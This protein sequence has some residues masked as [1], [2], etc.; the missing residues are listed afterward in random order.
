MDYGFPPGGLERLFARCDRIASRGMVHEPPPREPE[1]KEEPKPAEPEPAEPAE[2]QPTEQP[3]EPQSEPRAAEMADAQLKTLEGY[4]QESWGDIDDAR[5]EQAQKRMDERLSNPNGASLEQDE[6]GLDQAYKD[7]TAPGVFYDPD[8]RTEYITG[9]STPRDW[10][11]DFTKIPFW[12]DT[13]NSERYQQA[14][15][16]YSKLQSAGKPVDRVVG[17]SLG[18][19][20]ALE[21]QNRHGIPRSRTFGAPVLDLKTHRAKW[22]GTG[23]LWIP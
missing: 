20:V 21:M 11:D 23:T 16:A 22:N 14:T 12:G 17:H 8:T 18:G 6:H 5:Q 2:P 10:Y 13:G 3:K 15:D 19:S 4:P 9:S 7:A 1:T